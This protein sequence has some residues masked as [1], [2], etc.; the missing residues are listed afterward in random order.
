MVLDPVSVE[1]FESPI[2]VTRTSR[3]GEPGPMCGPTET[4]PLAAGASPPSL[5]E[6]WPLSC[7]L[8]QTGEIPAPALAQS[9]Q[10]LANNVLQE[11]ESSAGR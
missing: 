3:N 1:S 9:S 11:R 6:G 8:F 5:T 2:Q 7:A 10:S 4:E